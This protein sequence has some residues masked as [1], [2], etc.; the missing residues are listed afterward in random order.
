MAGSHG[1]TRMFARCP[2]GRA[3][4]FTL[5]ELLVV[6]TIIGMLMSLLLPAVQSTRESARMLQCQNNLKQYGL[7]LQ[8]YHATHKAFPPGNVGDLNKFLL[9]TW[10]TA[11]SMLLPY[12]EGDNV[13]R[14][15][16][17]NYPDPWGPPYSCFDFIDPLPR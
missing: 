10:W 8:N 6:I 12:M 5:I 2:A 9:D 17:Y 13:Y 7:A 16:N 1:E 14:L 3:L 11:Q 4:G 15:I